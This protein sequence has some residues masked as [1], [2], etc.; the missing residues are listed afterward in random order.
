MKAKPEISY[1]LILLQAVFFAFR[2]GT[3]QFNVFNL[4]ELQKCR[5]L[6]EQ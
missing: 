6:S 4:I 1:D 3:Q 2:L 5:N